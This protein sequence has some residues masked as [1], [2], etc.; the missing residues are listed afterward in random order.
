MIGRF[1]RCHEKHSAVVH[2]ISGRSTGDQANRKVRYKRALLGLDEIEVQRSKK[3]GL[4]DTGNRADWHQA[5]APCLS[6]PKPG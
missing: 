6:A 5:R 2:T 1:T 3:D 4:S